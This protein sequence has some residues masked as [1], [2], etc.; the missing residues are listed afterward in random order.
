MKSLLLVERIVLESLVQEDRSIIEISE[1]TGLDRIL[2]QN[3]LENFLL[4]SI[5]SIENSKYKINRLNFKKWVNNLNIKSEVKEILNSLVKDSF[6]TESDTI[7]KMRKVWINEGDQKILNSLLSQVDSFLSQIESKEKLKK[8][9]DKKVIMWGHS[10]YKDL[11]D[12][13]LMA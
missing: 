5:V 8:T 10:C 6:N 11:T 7:L 13:Y 9:K 12:Q 1:D 4:S 2:I 3:I